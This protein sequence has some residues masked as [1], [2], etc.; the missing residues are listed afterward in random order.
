VTSPPE[1]DPA[2]LRCFT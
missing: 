2:V 1:K